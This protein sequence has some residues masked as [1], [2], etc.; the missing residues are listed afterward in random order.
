ML[1]S[2]QRDLLTQACLVEAGLSLPFE[3]FPK[4]VDSK[5]HLTSELVRS[6]P[7]SRISRGYTGRSCAKQ[8]FELLRESTRTNPSLEVS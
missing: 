6:L 2:Q 5:S 4:K 7:G 1:M 8:R 3:S